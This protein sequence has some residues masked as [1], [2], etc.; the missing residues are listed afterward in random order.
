MVVNIASARPE[1]VGAAW[2]D[3]TVIDTSL[4]SLTT[5]GLVINGVSI[6]LSGATIVE[7][8]QGPATA[9]RKGLERLLPRHLGGPGGRRVADQV[10]A[11]VAKVGRPL[12]RTL[13]FEGHLLEG[14]DL[15]LQSGQQ[16]ALRS[17]PMRETTL[18]LEGRTA[19]PAA[20]LVRPRGCV[21]NRKR[22]TSRR[23]Y[24]NVDSRVD[25]RSEPPL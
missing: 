12:C 17:I 2:G 15:L 18:V 9:P 20:P 16:F 8:G 19:A 4:L 13:P 14:R 22:L 1:D 3:G 21:V 24:S 6:D 23:N 25:G 5:G 10:P 7:E 11:S